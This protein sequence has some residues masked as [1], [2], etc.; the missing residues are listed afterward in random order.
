VSLGVDLQYLGVLIL[1]PA[2]LTGDW[3]CEWR[4]TIGGETLRRSP[5]V[6]PAI[7]SFLNLILTDQLLLFFHSV[8]R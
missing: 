7:Q 4:K 1:T 6:P 3:Q 5:K 2:R 8:I